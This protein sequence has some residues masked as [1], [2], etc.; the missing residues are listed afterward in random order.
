[1]EHMAWKRGQTSMVEGLTDENVTEYTRLA[2]TQ[3]LRA[4][5]DIAGIQLRVNTESGIE[6]K[7]Q[8]AF[9][10]DGV[11]A[12]MKD[13]GRPVLL[14]LRGWGALPSTIEAAVQSGLPMR[15]SM[16]YWA[17]FMG[18]PY[19]PAETPA[20]YSY[21]D[22]LRYPRAYPVLQQVWSLGSHRLLLWGDP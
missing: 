3:L 18:F 21:A 9:Y 14:D 13:P 20:S 17:E 7:M 6:N 1:W 15:L 12:A 5:P 8:T 11:L 2:L 16:K 19:Q 22:F 4:C 10:R